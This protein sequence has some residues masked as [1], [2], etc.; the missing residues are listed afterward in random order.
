MDLN[1]D[2]SLLNGMG[3]NTIRT[4]DKVTLKLL[5]KAQAHGLKVIAGFWVDYG[6]D[7]SNA[8]VRAKLIKEFEE[9]V[10][11]FKNHP[12]VL[13]WA[14]GN[15][16]NYKVSGQEQLKA[17]YS[18]FNEMAGRAHQLEGGSFHPVSIVNGDLVN[19]GNPLYTSDD[20]HLPN[21]DLW[22]INVYRGKSFGS[23]FKEY[24]RLSQKPLWIAEYGA[25]AYNNKEEREDQKTQA[26][27]A[28][29]LWDEIVQ[30][31]SYNSNAA[32]VC[33]GASIM[34]FTD[35]YWKANGEWKASAGS[36][37]TGGMSSLGGAPD[38]FKNEEW[39]G[40]FAIADQGKN[41][42]QRFPR[43]VV[44]ILRNRFSCLNT[45][46]YYYAGPDNEKSCD[47]TSACCPAPYFFS[48]RGQCQEACPTQ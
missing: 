39:W 30:N 8:R 40:L 2:F 25:D 9:Y 46:N 29:N 6:L 13:F 43:K 5:D 35:E 18:L 14:I 12:A 37:E 22:G 38:N 20:A 23:L 45:G 47:V 48:Q 27:W 21:I 36:Q 10:K 16:S 7:F 1:R 44:N 24:Q 15:E 26:D 28:G 33:V 19:L 41:P 42:D 17:M 34:S 3:V 31:N 11:K 4:W 32:P